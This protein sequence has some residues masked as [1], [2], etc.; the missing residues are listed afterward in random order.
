MLKIVPSTPAENSTVPAIDMGPASMVT[1]DLSRRVYGLLGISLDAVSFPYLLQSVEKAVAQASPFLISTP[2]V[3][4]LIASQANSEFRESILQSDACLADGMPLIW[5]AKLLQ[6][7]I[8]ERIAGSDLFGRLKSAVG[9]S[10]PIRIFLFG[11]AD[12]VAETVCKKINAEKGGLHCVGVLNPGFGTIEEM[13]STP[14]IDTIN[15]SRPDLLAVF[16]G[17]QKAQTWLMHNHHRI[18]APVRAQFG[19]TINF[20]AG[21]VKRAPYLLRSTG[22]EWLWRIKEEPYLW[23]RYWSDGQALLKLMVICVLP[24][25]IDACLRRRTPGGLFIELQV[26]QGDCTVRLAGDAVAQNVDYAISH[27]RNALNGRKSI[28]IDVSE[29]RSIDSRMFGLLL[30]VKKILATRG[31]RLSFVGASPELRRIFQLNRFEY[32]LS[33]E[34][35]TEVNR[36]FQF[37]ANS[38][39][40]EK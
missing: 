21:T 9:R 2:N 24:L 38:A 23:R 4:F 29:V 18:Q 28:I 19:A 39:Q 26:G 7:P 13:S 1:D 30:M 11:G 3:N 37:A 35:D 33:R 6:V 14:I 10:R 25:M 27:F 5:I 40:V 31:M 8:N 16:F 32:L 34:C 36:P 17:A 15:A 20:E 12:G 22:F